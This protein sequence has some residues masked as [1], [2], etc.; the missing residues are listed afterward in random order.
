VR[1]QQRQDGGDGS[2]NTERPGRAP[3][4]QTNYITDERG[5]APQHGSN[6]NAIWSGCTRRRFAPW[7][8]IVLAAPRDSWFT[9][10]MLL[11]AI[12]ALRPRQWL[13]NGFVFAPLLFGKAFLNTSK[14][15]LSLEAFAL[16]SAVASSIYILNDILDVERDRAHPTKKN[17]PI[18]A[19]RLPI[20]VAAAI[21]VLLGGSALI[22]A[23]VHLPLFGRLL[24]IYA[25]INVSYSLGL[26]HVVI[27]DIF[28]IAIGFVL[29]VFSGAI[30]IDVEPSRWLLTCT[31]FFSLFLAACKRRGEISLVGDSTATR[32]VLSSYS[33]GFVDQIITLSATGTILSYALYALD[34]VT[35]AKLGTH[36]LIFTL[37]FVLYG[38]LRYLHIVQ[39]LGQGGSPTEELL[40]D[41]MMLLTVACYVALVAWLLLHPGH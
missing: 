16:F 40:K 31:I 1:K 24:G 29:R 12:Q 19:G 18:A 34:P 33:V 37:P 8:F 28:A 15:A 11:A 3:G 20:P 22:Y 39:D 17:R 35:I 26:K 13:K 5:S 6:D 23:L 41:R 38:V 27:I 30:V 9:N 21:G 2:A 10:R 32:S 25:A 4:A 36:D 14:L 7:D